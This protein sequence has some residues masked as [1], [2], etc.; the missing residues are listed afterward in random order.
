MKVGQESSEPDASQAQR[1]LK[2]P[3]IWLVE[4]VARAI[5]P[6]VW[7]LMDDYPA[8]EGPEIIYGDRKRRSI[9]TARAAIAAMR[10]DLRNLV[11]IVWQ[12][13]LEDKS[14]PATW[15]ADR[16]IDAALL[17]AP[18]PVGLGEP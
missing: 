9:E 18:P 4:R 10:P 6:N 16:M 3:P 13:A 15:W 5:D 14:V 8:G 17:P 12:T 1:P 7:A 2:P 11:D